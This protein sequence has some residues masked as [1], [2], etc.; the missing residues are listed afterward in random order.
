MFG[1]N[2]KL[3][4]LKDIIDLQ[5]Q[6]HEAEIASLRREHNT[7]V[8]YLRKKMQEVEDSC[9]YKISELKSSL[10]SPPKSSEQPEA[11]QEALSYI[12]GGQD[13]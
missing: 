12:Y 10:T 3:R 11:M 1:T 8:H 4:H 13:G 6:K 5:A 7:E 9:R 2:E